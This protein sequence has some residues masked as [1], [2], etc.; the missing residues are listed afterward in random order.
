MGEGLGFILFLGSWGS[1]ASCFGFFFVSGL[2]FRIWEFG[3]FG[4]TEPRIG[5]KLRALG[6]KEP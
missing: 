1:S 6:V 4:F 5:L 2:G 3:H